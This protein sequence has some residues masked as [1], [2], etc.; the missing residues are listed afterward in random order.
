MYDGGC[1]RLDQCVA[2]RLGLT[3]HTVPHPC[4]VQPCLP[5]NS[6]SSR[7]LPLESDALIQRC[8]HHLNPAPNPQIRRRPKRP[9]LSSPPNRNTKLH[10]HHH[11]I[12]TTPQPPR[13]STTEAATATTKNTSPPHHH[14]A[15]APRR[16]R[17]LTTQRRPTQI[18]SART[19]RA[20]LCPGCCDLPD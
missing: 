13:D 10:H 20:A 8:K 7:S 1:T 12:S 3:S 16:H 18:N 6:V 5:I 14:G 9:S 11:L 15:T 17:R 2:A 19:R 4:A